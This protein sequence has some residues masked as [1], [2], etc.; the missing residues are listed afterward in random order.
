MSNTQQLHPLHRHHTTCASGSPYA[1]HHSRSHTQ[2][3]EYRGS[4]S[5]MRPP[6]MTTAAAPS[7][8]QAIQPPS[9]HHFRHASPY[10]RLLTRS[11]TVAGLTTIRTV[12][13][14]QNP[15]Y[16]TFSPRIR[17]ARSL[18]SASRR[19]AAA[20][21]WAHVPLSYGARQQQQQPL[22][23]TSSSLSS[24][25]SAR[26]NA[27]ISTTVLSDHVEEDESDGAESVSELGSSVEASSSLSSSSTTTSDEWEDGGQAAEE[28]VIAVAPIASEVSV[29]RKV[30][31][32]TALGE[33]R[34][35]K[36]VKWMAKRRAMDI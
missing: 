25:S 11:G 23:R 3:T 28:P 30:R 35:G 24:G 33:L 2:L 36:K 34:G 26:R 15:Y 19:G 12:C 17:A 4:L 6:T 5:R 22:R 21:Q 16:S 14:G 7:A 29:L 8:W 32:T 1:L 10:P 13:P 27:S 18:S 9:Y 20:R 31:S